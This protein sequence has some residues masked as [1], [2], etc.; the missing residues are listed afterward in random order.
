MT[1]PV[2]RLLTEASRS[3]NSQASW[4]AVA[5]GRGPDQPDHRPHRKRHMVRRVVKG[6]A[7]L[8]VFNL[9]MRN[10]QAT[11]RAE[12]SRIS[13]GSD[14]QATIKPSDGRMYRQSHAFLTGEVGGEKVNIGYSSRYKVWATMHVQ[15]PHLI[16]WCRHLGERIRSSGD[17]MTHTGLDLVSAGSRPG[18][19]CGNSLATW[20]WVSVEANGSLALTPALQRRPHQ[21][22]RW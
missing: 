17:V 19:L 10:M 8:R 21:T 9:G 12:S 22:G 15:I 11:N 20:E 1:L 4:H 14:T 13:A 16:A 18:W 2:P 5:S 7:N 3:R 6:M